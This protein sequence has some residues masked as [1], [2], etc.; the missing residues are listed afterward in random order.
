VGP[1]AGIPV[2]PAA[3]NASLVAGWLNQSSPPTG[4]ELTNWLNKWSFGGSAG[5]L[6]GAGFQLSNGSSG[7]ENSVETGLYTPQ[8]GLKLG[9]NICISQCIHD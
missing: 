7:W 1:A 6:F 5:N 4:N 9:Y 8:A 3:I 2:G